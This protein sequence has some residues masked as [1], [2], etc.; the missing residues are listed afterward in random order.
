[1]EKTKE[2]RTEQQ[3]DGFEVQAAPA[4]ARHL[5]ARRREKGRTPELAGTLAIT[6]SLRSRG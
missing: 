4:L 1:M 3:E 5:R 2:G 6:A